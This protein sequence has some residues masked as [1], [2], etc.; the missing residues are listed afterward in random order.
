MT[1]EAFIDSLKKVVGPE[2]NHLLTEAPNRPGD[3][4][5]FCREHAV[6][7]TALAKAF[8]HKL[9]IVHGEVSI[10]IET[11]SFNT[12]E[13]VPE[14]KH[15]WCKGL[16]HQIIDLSARMDCFS[17]KCKRHPPVM[18]EGISGPLGVLITDDL[19]AH[20]I[21]YD[22][23]YLVYTPIRTEH[24]SIEELLTTKAVTFLKGREPAQIARQAFVHICRLLTG[25]ARS[26]IG[27]MNQRQS[28]FDLQSL[29]DSAQN[30]FR[31]LRGTF[32]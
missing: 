6:I 13:C 8:G 24:D 19:A 29:D 4:G 23:P 31:C 11:T 18:N 28:L 14:D 5:W 22:R 9:D 16:Y 12:I 10:I 30:V 32:S 17:L 7:T 2:L 15:W 3:F 27:R 21:T 20:K 26:Y 25:S 1:R